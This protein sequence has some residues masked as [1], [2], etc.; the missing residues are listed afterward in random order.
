MRMIDTGDGLDDNGGSPQSLKKNYLY[1]TW[2]WPANFPAPSAFEVVF[3]TGTDPTV[4]NNYL[5]PI[6]EA[7][8]TDRGLQIALPIKTTIT[9]V[10][11]F[12]R[13]VYA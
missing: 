9:G 3:C 7:L 1:A 12:V 4:T 6:Q 13:A 2:V 8:P 5:V 10:N 11:A